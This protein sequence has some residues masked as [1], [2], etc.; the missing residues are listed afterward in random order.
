MV[1]V[2][3]QQDGNDSGAL[4]PAIVEGKLELF[5]L[6]GTLAG[7][8]DEDRDRLTGGKRVLNLLKPNRDLFHLRR[9]GGVVALEDVDIRHSKQDI[10][11]VPL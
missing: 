7:L 6:V 8:S 5:V 2:D 4:R 1:E 10:V 11:I 9:V 3:R